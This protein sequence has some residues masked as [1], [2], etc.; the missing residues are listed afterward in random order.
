MHVVTCA[1]V[2]AVHLSTRTRCRPVGSHPQQVLQPPSPQKA[3]ETTALRVEPS[4]P[5]AHFR[6]RPRRSATLGAQSLSRTASLLSNAFARYSYTLSIRFVLLV[7]YEYICELSPVGL[8]HCSSSRREREARRGETVETRSNHEIYEARRRRR[9]S[10]AYRRRA[11]MRYAR[12]VETRALQSRRL[13]LNSRLR[14]TSRRDRRRAEKTR[15]QS[16][17]SESPI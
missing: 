12:H 13:N 5:P 6:P 3:N 11:E 7:M 17:A 15:S 9:A 2:Q 8:R 14:S 1:Y 4:Q 10:N 16:L